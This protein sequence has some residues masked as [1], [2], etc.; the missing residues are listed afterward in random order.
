[1]RCRLATAVDIESLTRF[2]QLL[3]QHVLACNRR[4]WESPPD[5]G[6]YR[7]LIASDDARAFIAEIDDGPVGYIA[8]TV[9]QRAGAPRVTGVIH[10]AYVEP[11][12]RGALVGRELMRSLLEFFES[13]AVEDISLVYAE[14]NREAEAFWRG[15]GFEPVM[16]TAN[17][18]PALVREALQGA[19]RG[20]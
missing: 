3:D 17:A 1:M 9:R 2:H 6:Y 11:P 15:L 20:R 14:G 4:L 18:A 7:G 10:H 8:G 13:R 5:P 19:E 12:H 16:H